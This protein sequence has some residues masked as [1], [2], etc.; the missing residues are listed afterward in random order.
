MR[1]LWPEIAHRLD[2]QRRGRGPALVAVVGAVALLLAAI[3]FS[4]RESIRRI[5]AE[6]LDQ[7]LKH[8]I[9]SFYSLVLSRPRQTADL[10]PIANVDANPYGINV[11]L[12]Q[13]VEEV[14][15]RR[16][17]ELIRDAGFAWIKQQVVWGEIEVPAKGRYGERGETWAKYD[18][19][20][21]IAREHGLN[22]ILR[23]DTSP[24]WARPNSD[25]L[26]TPPDDYEDY[27]DFVH[28]VVS[29]YRGKVRHYQIWNEPNLAFE[30][31]GAR[32]DAAAYVQLLQIA[33][34]RAKEADPDCVVLSAALAPTIEESDI[35]WNDLKYLQ[36][37]YDAGARGYFDV[38]SANAYGLRHG[39]DDWRLDMERDVNFS[40]PILL[41]ELMVRNGDAGKP[42]WA[43]EVGWNALPPDFGETPRYGVVTREQQA[44]YTAR[45][46]LRA[47]EEWPWMG[48]LTLWHFRMVHAKDAMQQHYYFNV[49]DEQFLPY[50][51]YHAMRDL[52]T[53]PAVV[54]RGYHQETHWALSFAPAWRSEREPRASLGS[55]V[56][57]DDPAQPL[58]F[59]FDGTT[60]DFV[61]PRGPELGRLRVAIDGD[62]YAATELP[63][64]AEGAYLDLYSPDE[65]WQVRVPVARGLADGIHSVV[66]APAQP[67]AG[68]RHRVAIDGIIV[69]G[70]WPRDRILK[71]GVELALLVAGLGVTG[72]RVVRR[73]RGRR[74]GVTAGYVGVGA[75]RADGLEHLSPQG[76]TKRRQAAAF[77][78]RR[79]GGRP[80]PCSSPE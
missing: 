23:L 28:A 14:K 35:G 55:Y 57:T 39:P 38:L 24:Q 9:I 41:R 74:R 37:M 2:R 32:P 77:L 40:R 8:S 67:V 17:M 18:R 36:A 4:Q 56:W 64:S 44:R 58:T 65:Q 70:P 51:V 34:R 68:S 22:L 63:S 3:A 66:V 20:V 48:V 47:Q 46:F 11:F 1:R 54:R 62:P 19:I 30:W 80:S 31:G 5:V 42:I 26:E 79:T 52:A 13:E 27:G 69:D 72:S 60:L 25:K 76:K 53:A 15:V 33:Y 16:S 21:D 78:R 50:P 6:S 43:A 45:A 59:Q 73:G 12:E 29:R 10:V 61:V 7:E 49:V 75:T 71:R